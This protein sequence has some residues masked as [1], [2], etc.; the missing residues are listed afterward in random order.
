MK[1]I[2]RPK[3]SRGRDIRASRF[4]QQIREIAK[5]RGLKAIGVVYTDD[6]PRDKG[7]PDDDGCWS[8]HK[9]EG[10]HRRWSLKFEE[11]HK[12]ILMD[13]PTCSYPFLIIK[14]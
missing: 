14:S 4:F 9:C 13:C 11:G 10:K 3:D 7:D 5:K 8:C 6:S 12:D 2:V 1:L